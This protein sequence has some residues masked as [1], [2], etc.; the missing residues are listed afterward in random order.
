MCPYHLGPSIILARSYDDNRF[1]VLG[2]RAKWSPISEP[3]CQKKSS[4]GFMRTSMLLYRR[5]DARKNARREKERPETSPGGAPEH[6]TD[7]S[8]QGQQHQW[9]TSPLSEG[10]VNYFDALWQAIAEM[11][12]KKWD[13]STWDYQTLLACSAEETEA[14]Q[15]YGVEIQR[16]AYEVVCELQDQRDA[17]EASRAQIKAR[18]E[19]KGPQ[20]EES[21]VPL[22]SKTH[23]MQQSSSETAAWSVENQPEQQR[24]YSCPLA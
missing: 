4:V 18:A 15:Q 13:V 3:T 22:S 1:P 6:P 14:I 7:D 12:P 5:S 17:A 9:A 23:L 10:Y 24:T 2:T 21:H 20:A 8:A 11:S 16:Q 19:R